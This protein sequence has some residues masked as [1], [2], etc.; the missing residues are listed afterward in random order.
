MEAEI[1]FSSSTTKRYIDNCFDHEKSYDVDKFIPENI[2]KLEEKL[3]SLFNEFST[4]IPPDSLYKKY[5]IN[6]EK[7]DYSIYSGTGGNMYIYWRYFIYKQIKNEKSEDNII[8]ESLENFRIS[9]DTNNYI[10]KE[11][12]KNKNFYP[13]KEPTAFFHG[14]IGLYT[15]NCIYSI[16]IGNREK[17]EEYL[18]AILEF[19]QFVIGK[20]SEDEL[21]YGNAGYLYSLLMIKREIRL[22]NQRMKFSNVYKPESDI[23][24]NYENLNTENIRNLNK[25]FDWNKAEKTQKSKPTKIK[26]ETV[27]CN[28]NFEEFFSLIDPIICEVVN[29]LYKIGLEKKHIYNTKFLIY[30][31]SRIDS[32]SNP[33]SLYIGG[34]HGVAGVL[35]IMLEAI[36]DIPNYFDN[37]YS[38]EMK[39]DI[40]YSLIE[41]IKLKT[42]MKTGNFPSSFSHQMKTSVSESNDKVQFCHGA[43]GFIHL[44]LLAWKIYDNDQFLN[45]A[46][47]LGEL[48]WKKG[49]LKKGY[50]VCHG[51]SGNAY[52]LYALFKYTNQK[53]WYERFIDYL[54]IVFNKSANKIISETEDRSRYVTGVPDTPYSLMEGIGGLICLISDFLSSWHSRNK[55][56]DYVVFPGY[57]I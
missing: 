17:F 47:D 34:A 2:P 32:K 11:T 14:P 19:K 54:F 20:Y 51:I 15:M 50:S 38:S 21:L 6:K 41:L 28:I 31:F 30:P 12:Y 29:F 33:S 26:V 16:L 27:V 25:N 49:I 22:N 5:S 37:Q 7:V 46:I 9:V 42:H 45:C 48:V 40:F 43:P 18:D 55:N 13:E 36:Q 53:I 3:E 24:E 57:E 1:E 23:S 10:F 39:K 56:I 44:F 35:Y 4:V 52:C 8:Q